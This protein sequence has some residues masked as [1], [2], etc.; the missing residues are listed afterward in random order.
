MKTDI[1]ERTLSKLPTIQIETNAVQGSFYRPYFFDLKDYG[2]SKVEFNSIFFNEH[3]PESELIN[4][5]YSFAFI[6]QDKLRTIHA[7]CEDGSLMPFNSFLDHLHITI[8]TTNLFKTSKYLSRVFRSVRYG[9]FFN[10]LNIYCNNNHCGKQTD[11]ISLISLQLA[12]ELGWR[13]ACDGASAQFTLFYA[14][15]LVKGHCVVSDKIKSDV[16]IYGEDN[17]KSELKLGNNLQYVA[18]EPVKLN[19]HLRMDIQTILNLWELFGPQQYLS[20]ANNAISKYKE[21]LLSGKL[22]EYLDDFEN[23]T[24]NEYKNECWTLQK[25]IWHKVEYQRY[26]GL[27]RLGWSMLKNSIRTYA[28]NKAGTPVFR[29]PVPG[30]FRGYLRVDLREHDELGNFISSVE[31]GTV[32]LDKLGN[33]WVHTEDIEKLL[34]TLGGGDLDDQV[35]IITIEN[36]EA[37]IF[38]N[39]NAYG[40]FIIKR[41]LFEGNTISSDIKL[42]GKV[43]AAKMV[44]QFTSKPSENKTGNKIFDAFITSI[45]VESNFFTPYTKPNLL[46]TLVKVI[47]N[48]T[49]IG[50][51]ANG[52]M[53]RTSIGITNKKV[54]KFL[55]KEYPWNLERVIDASIK[56][57]LDAKED[58]INVSNMFEYIM[59]NT[60]EIPKS[61]QNRI[62]VRYQTETRKAKE[63]PVDQLLEALNLLIDKAD[64]DILGYGSASKGNR[65]PG[66]IDSCDVPVIDLGK[67]ALE[68]PF[69]D[70]ASG[71]LKA[72]NQ[73]VAIMLEQIKSSPEIEIRRRNGINKIQSQLLK[74]LNEYSAAERQLISNSWAYAVY[75]SAASIHDSILWIGDRDGLLGTSDDTINMLSNVGN[76]YHV[77]TSN[78]LI[79]E[80]YFAFNKVEVKVNCIRIW[81]KKEIDPDNFSS[82]TEIMIEDSSVL[83]GEKL[84]NLGDEVH[85]TSGLYK[86]K[87][88]VPTISKRNNKQILKNSLSIYIEC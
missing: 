73:Q 78:G 47:N 32:E 19:N 58:M 56:D 46:R 21:D 86:V 13:E 17:I 18:I 62:P 39:P 69:H 40:E 50:A 61:L 57:G 80:R 70:K 65:I 9:S 3:D 43:T 5:N 48:N 51:V 11:G 16:V 2:F 74:S 8:N 64:R 55:M 44:N 30:G 12:N 27:L 45:K 87:D 88:I 41:I 37:C 85:I 34:E 66:L 54:Q 35:G 38:R 71:M 24:A 63:H 36:G 76:A 7:Y 1:N 22:I 23:I 10:N 6:R 26:P 68:N 82:V 60:I 67:E 79:M 84:F 77:R 33:L 72:Y 52:E 28:Q 53:V 75:K 31:K 42:V 15:G 49:S 29:I 81:D 14:D 4:G 83:L 20:W 25:A 59:V